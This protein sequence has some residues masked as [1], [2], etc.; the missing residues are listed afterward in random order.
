MDFFSNVL[1]ILKEHYFQN[2]SIKII[3]QSSIQNRYFIK[4]EPSK[5]LIIK[6]FILLEGL[7]QNK[8]FIQMTSS[9]T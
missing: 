6:Q 5:S 3:Q 9:Q 2:R 7:L 1:P 4:F 8:N